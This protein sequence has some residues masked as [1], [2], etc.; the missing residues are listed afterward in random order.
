MDQRHIDL[1]TAIMESLTSELK[2]MTIKDL[3][4]N[5]QDYIGGESA[6]IKTYYEDR[7]GYL[8]IVFTETPEMPHIIISFGDIDFNEWAGILDWAVYANEG[9][10][11]GYWGD[12]DFHSPKRTL[13][14]L[15]DQLSTQLMKGN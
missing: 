11:L 14:N 7:L 3:P 2:D 12:V 6:T 5:V 10:E 4:K 9:H 15:F 13:E 1:Q 8:S